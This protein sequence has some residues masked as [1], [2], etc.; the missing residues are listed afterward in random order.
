MKTTSGIGCPK[1]QAGVNKYVT[2]FSWPL[3][4][5]IKSILI[6]LLKYQGFYTNVETFINNSKEEREEI[7]QSRMTPP[8]QKKK[9]PVRQCKGEI[10]QIF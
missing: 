9:K 10:A 3:I 4:I 6:A 7:W 8:P 5:E 2:R 1:Q